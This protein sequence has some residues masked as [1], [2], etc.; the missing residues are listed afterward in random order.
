MDSENDYDDDEDGEDDSENEHDEFYD[1]LVHDTGGGQST[2]RGVRGVH[3]SGYLHIEARIAHLEAESSQLKLQVDSLQ[4]QSAIFRSILDEMFLLLS[5]TNKNTSA[6]FNDKLYGN[7]PEAPQLAEPTVFTNDFVDEMKQRIFHTVVEKML[8]NRSNAPYASISSQVQGMLYPSSSAAG[9]AA[10]SFARHGAYPVGSIDFG[11]SLEN[12]LPSGGLHALDGMELSRLR[13]RSD[14][15]NDSDHIMQ[16][17]SFDLAASSVFQPSSLPIGRLNSFYGTEL[18]AVPFGR[19][20]LELLST[21][22]DILTERDRMSSYDYSTFATTN[23]GTAT[24]VVGNDED[25]LPLSKKQRNS[26]V[27]ESAD[28]SGRVVLSSDGLAGP[29]VSTTEGAHSSAR[30]RVPIPGV[31]TVID[32]SVIAEVVMFFSYE[33]YFF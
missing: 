9:V 5:A 30:E 20:S 14:I 32:P 11:M 4:L 16:P 8:P 6:I 31:S 3:S 12:A 10:N 7:Q 26:D 23:A 28:V 19:S 17:N 1:P 18:S 21:S 22:A 2:G 27:L 24:T 29:Y 25:R 13:G 15:G 33:Y